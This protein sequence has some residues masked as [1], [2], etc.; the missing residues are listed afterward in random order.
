MHVPPIDIGCALC[1]RCAMYLSIKFYCSFLLFNGNLHYLSSWTG[2]QSCANNIWQMFITQEVFPNGLLYHRLES[3]ANIY[4]R[5]MEV[6]A[7]VQLLPTAVCSLSCGWCCLASHLNGF[8]AAG[9]RKV[10]S[11]MASLQRTLPHTQA[12]LTCHMP[13]ET[14]KFPP[15]KNISGPDHWQKK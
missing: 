10:L 7:W 15:H 11:L 9:T 12:L 5:D 3:Y 13:C 1:R 2:Y 6:T 14:W 4:Y 8:K